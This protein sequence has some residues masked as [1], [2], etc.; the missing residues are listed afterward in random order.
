VTL[1]ESL[2]ALVPVYGA[3]LVGGITFASCLALPVPSSLAM[4]AAGAFAATGDLSLAAVV[5]AAIVGAVAGD[6]AG[7]WLGRSGAGWLA[8]AS[9]RPS[10]ARLMDRARKQLDG[11]AFATI[12]L[13][14]WLF[15]P[16]GPWVNLAAGAMRIGWGR[17]TLGSVS[18]EATWVALYVGLGWGFAA[19]VDRMGSLMG[20]LAGF[21][22]AAGL[23]GVLGHQLLRQRRRRRH[24]PTA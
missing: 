4:L 6:Q 14:R 12:Y 15:S 24:P 7:W 9:A 2:L 11:N 18:G 16:L 21:A 19:Q 3:A 17:F 8:R 22:A 1:T 23:A 5:G 10:R 20:S 13:T